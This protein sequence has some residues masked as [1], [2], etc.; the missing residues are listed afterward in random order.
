MSFLLRHS[1]DDAAALIR[2]GRAAPNT[3]RG[4]P[5]AGLRVWRLL[6]ISPA[7]GTA[8]CDT[9]LVWQQV[10][11]GWWSLGLTW[12]LYVQGDARRIHWNLLLPESCPSAVGGVSAHL[13]GAAIESAGSFEECLRSLNQ[14]SHKAVMGGHPAVG[15]NARLDSALRAMVG[16]PFAALV[17]SRAVTNAGIANEVARWET[18]AQFVRDEHL[19]RPSLERDN[20]SRAASYLQLVQAGLER[21]TAAMQEGA[22]ETRT[23]FAA[24]SSADFEQL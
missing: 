5:V 7:L 3:S 19:A 1:L 18:E 12:G 23:L 11:R 10:V 22:W 17:V 15:A 20:H 24:S 13:Q 6:G 8:V 21:A 16:K 4:F 9:D 14:L 2:G